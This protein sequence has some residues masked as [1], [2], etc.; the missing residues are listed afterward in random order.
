MPTCITL[1]ESCSSRYVP[2]DTLPCGTLRFNSIGPPDAGFVRDRDAGRPFVFYK[3][4][5]DNIHVIEHN[6]ISVVGNVFSATMFKVTF[7]SSLHI[8]F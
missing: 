3:N 1:N 7:N 8:I 5:I 4:A 6:V 2:C